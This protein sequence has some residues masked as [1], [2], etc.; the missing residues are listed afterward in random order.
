MS[1][2]R[3]HN[4]VTPDNPQHLPTVLLCRMKCANTNGEEAWYVGI[5]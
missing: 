5:Q 2:S 4:L 1:L 3:N